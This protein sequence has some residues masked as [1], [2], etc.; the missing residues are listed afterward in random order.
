MTDKTNTLLAFLT[1][2]NGSIPTV[3]ACN[4]N[5]TEMLGF[6]ESQIKHVPLADKLVLCEESSFLHLDDLFRSA[7]TTSGG[8]FTSAKMFNSFHYAVSV[9]LH[10]VHEENDLFTLYLSV[11]EN[12]SVDPISTLPNGWA[13][14]SR[15][16]YLINQQKMSLKNVILI[17][18]EADNFSTINY[19]YDY[20]I[21]DQYLILLGERLQNIMK[22]FGFVIRFS[23]AKFAILIEDY[24]QLPEDILYKRIELICQN[25]CSTLA[26][27]IWISEQLPITKSFS[28][29]V[30]SPGYDYNCYHSMD[31]A[32]ETEKE[33]AKKY[34]INKY[35]IASAEPAE[36]LLT[37]KLIIEALPEAII[38]HQ[39]QVH[40][41]PQYDMK[42]RELT[43][44]EALSRWNDE[45]LGFIPPNIFVAITEDIGLHFEFDLWVF[46]KVCTQLMDWQYQEIQVPRVAINISFKTMEMTTFIERIKYILNKTGCPTHF[47]ELEVT[48]TSSINNTKMLVDNMLKVK[49]LGM[50]IAVDD[51]GTG[52]SSLSLVRTFHLSLDKLKLDRSLVDKVCHTELDRNFIKHI[53]ELGKILNLSVLAEGVETQEQLDLL[54]ELG[55]D[56][57]QGYY[58][59]KALPSDDIARLIENNHTS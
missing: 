9:K 12:K 49:E 31:I 48:E 7:M 45:N 33:K 41:Q 13:L 26:E 10:C 32:A 5:F 17:I 44:L 27:P 2:Y 46:E 21:G 38:K 22:G 1:I 19:R 56:Y 39:I 20:A 6:S 58:F 50:H 29:G 36:E 24:E 11:S 30:S 16:N 51:F 52:Y 55:C 25:L 15:V 40:Y 59:S 23:N 28:I 35:F 3:K 57:A 14:T 18:L 37:R 4:D 8:V 54:M 47:I 53:I 42:S 34:S 43:G